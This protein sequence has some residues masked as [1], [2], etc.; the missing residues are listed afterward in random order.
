MRARA[1]PGEDAATLKAPSAVAE[2]VA[3]LL[4]ADFETGYRLEMGSSSNP[5]R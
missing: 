4:K 3:D 1:Y 5:S 2:A